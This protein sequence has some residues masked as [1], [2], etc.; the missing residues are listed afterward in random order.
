MFGSS[1]AAATL[2]LLLVQR[3]P[4]LHALAAFLAG[5]NL[6]APIWLIACLGAAVAWLAPSTP[7]RGLAVIYQGVRDVS[8]LICLVLAFPV[9]SSEATIAGVAAMVLAVLQ[10]YR[11]TNASGKWRASDPVDLSLIHI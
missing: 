6:S 3:S 8:A 5:P 10:S 4:N 2:S 7:H 11:T 9:I 1:I